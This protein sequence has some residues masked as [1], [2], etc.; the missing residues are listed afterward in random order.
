MSDHKENWRQYHPPTIPIYF[1]DIE[2]LKEM[3]DRNPEAISVQGLNQMLGYF[4]EF[5]K[6]E[7]AALVRDALWQRNLFA[8]EDEK[9]K[10]D[11]APPDDGHE[12]QPSEDGKHWMRK[13]TADELRNYLKNIDPE[14]EG[15]LNNPFQ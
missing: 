12:W 7:K 3:L 10:P 5:E 15:P 11:F 1:I 8:G 9:P 13:P 14:K 6:F 2:A 4:E